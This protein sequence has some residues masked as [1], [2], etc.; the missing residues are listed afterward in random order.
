MTWSPI[1]LDYFN[2]SVTSLPL[3]RM[4]YLDGIVELSTVNRVE[5][6]NDLLSNPVVHYD[7]EEAMSL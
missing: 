3:A 2:C 7:A 4:C 5:T 1:L 6:R